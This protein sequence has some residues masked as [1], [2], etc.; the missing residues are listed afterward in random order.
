MKKQLVV[1]PIALVITHTV[2]IVVMWACLAATRPAEIGAA[3]E[4]VFGVIDV[5]PYYLVGVPR[6]VAEAGESGPAYPVFFGLAGGIQ[7]FV[8]GLIVAYLR[9]V[10]TRVKGA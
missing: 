2:V 5:L 8:V 1:I 7:W 10:I 3:W 9:L 4:Y 6:S